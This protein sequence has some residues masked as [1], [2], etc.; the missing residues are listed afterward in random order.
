[1]QNPIK[2]SYLRNHL[3][4]YRNHENFGGKNGENFITQPAKPFN[5]DM[6]HVKLSGKLRK[7][8][9]IIYASHCNINPIFINSKSRRIPAKSR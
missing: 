2:I 3:N 1:M 6:K 8:S 5:K 9:V 4:V 7:L